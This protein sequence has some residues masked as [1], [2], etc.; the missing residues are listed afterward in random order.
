MELNEWVMLITALG[1]IEGV[2]QLI[3]WWA[4]RHY[5]RRKED[6]SADAAEYETERQQVDWLEKRLAQR[7]AKVDALYAEVR[8]LENE[9]LELVYRNHELE[10]Q[11]KEVIIK[12]CDVRGC[13]N[14]KP[15]SDY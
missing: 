13:G 11:L 12:R 15:P 10:L 9:K 1:G 7:D 5:E 8:K 3:K 6:A 4:N 14:R 2:K